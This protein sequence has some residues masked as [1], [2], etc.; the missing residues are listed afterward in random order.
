VVVV[1]VTHLCRSLSPTLTPSPRPSFPDV[2]RVIF[3]AHVSDQRDPELHK[4]ILYDQVT[5]NQGLG[6]D[7]VTGTFS[8]PVTGVYQFNYS[9]LGKTDS[10]NTAMHLVVNQKRVNYIHSI[11]KAEQ[12][13]TASRSAILSLNSGDKVWVTLEQGGVW[14]E[15]RA[16]SFQGLLLA[17]A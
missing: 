14:T 2:P 13:Q 12:A 17:A 3:N 15:Q 4:P 7:P 1:I 8:A 11:L 6:Y 16:I 10:E 5:V 9:L